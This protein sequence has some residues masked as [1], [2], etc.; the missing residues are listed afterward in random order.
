MTAADVDRLQPA[1]RVRHSSS[2]V[3][4]YQRR[5]GELLVVAVGQWTCE[6][7]ADD[8]EVIS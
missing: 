6:W 5:R 4:V 7:I 8:C 3:G 2:V 1:D